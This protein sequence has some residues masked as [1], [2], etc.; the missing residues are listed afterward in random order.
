MTEKSVV[1]SGS[2]DDLRSAQVRFLEEAA[3]LGPLHVLLWSDAAVR[4]LEGKAPKFPEAERQYLLGAIRY[5]DRVTI[6]RD[7]AGP[8]TLSL[9]DQLQPSTWAVDEASDN[10]AK[11]A[12]CRAHGLQYHVVRQEELASVPDCADEPAEPSD[13]KR[14]IVTGCY[15]WLHSGH[16][17]FF[18]EVSE[19]GDLYVVVGNDANLRLLKGDGHPLF[20][21]RQRQYLAQSIRYV[22]Q[23][24]IAT[25]QGWLDAEPE[26]RRIRPH[27][28]AVNEDG[29]RGGKRPYCEAHG[30]EYR[31]LKRLPKTGLPPRQSTDLRGF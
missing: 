1:L 4:R 15:D 20:P 11:R 25:G 18:E 12:Y 7:P 8:D 16:V 26:I 2:F 3:R 6:C 29:D 21:E 10:D 5:V 13:R 22:K 30:I 28:Y 31:V 19:L 23:A 27:I 24:L 17:R 14:V 9:P